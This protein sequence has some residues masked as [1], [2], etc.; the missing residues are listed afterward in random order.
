VLE[1]HNNNKASRTAEFM[2]LF[3]AMESSRPLG[4]RLFEDPY[5][6]L[7]LRPSFRFLLLLSRVP[8]LS[9]AIQAWID[10]SWPGAR[11]SGVARTRLIDDLLGTCVEKGVEQVV[12][13]GAGFDSRPYRIPGIHQTVVFEVD[14]PDTQEMKKQVMRRALPL[15]LRHVRFLGTDF[16]DREFQP[17]MAAA[18]Y[19]QR[20]RTFFIWEGV[21]NYLDE[22]A[23][24]GMLRWISN[25]A[26]GSRVVF[27]Y[28]DKRVLERPQEFKGTKR[29]FRTLQNSGEPWTLG[30][31][32]SLVKRYVASCGLELIEDLGAEDYRGRYFGTKAARMRGYEF[33]RVA[34]ADVPFR[35][36]RLSTLTD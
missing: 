20:R 25:A 28:V 36:G 17:L 9:H 2:A 29:L 23:V 21:T 7:F 14:H 3:R 4:E 6:H 13:L 30:L 33:Y 1:R 5:A 19:D 18:G 15:S 32:P 11:T 24:D 26:P 34:V 8:S 16:N 12:I 35:S 31:V 22:P 10:F 27:T